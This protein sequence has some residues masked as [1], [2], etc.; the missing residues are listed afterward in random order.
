MGNQELR[1]KGLEMATKWLRLNDYQLE[2][3]GR[4]ALL[5]EFEA[6]YR[7]CFRNALK[8]CDPP[9]HWD[10]FDVFLSKHHS[11]EQIS[12]MMVQ[13]G[14]PTPLIKHEGEYFWDHRNRLPCLEILKDFDADYRYWMKDVK[15]SI[16]GL[17]IYFYGK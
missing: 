7:T 4:V 13:V 9:F 15:Y 16:D 8:S 6:V 1:Q 2:Y 3:I 5:G 12:Q 11:A 17:F 14:F 10:E